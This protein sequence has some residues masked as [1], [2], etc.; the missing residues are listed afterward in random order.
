MET[1]Q[2]SEPVKPKRRS[3]GWLIFIAIAL[4]LTLPFHYCTVNM[5]VFPK[6]HLSLEHTFITQDDIEKACDDYNHAS[7][8]EQLI[9][10]RDPYYVALQDNGLIG[11]KR[12]RD[13]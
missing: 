4:A 5:S 9:M 13:K 11:N 8:F 10:D 6:D 7:I 1:Q 3:Y 12:K 2:P